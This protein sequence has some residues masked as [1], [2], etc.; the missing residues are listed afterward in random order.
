MLAFTVLPVTWV[1]HVDAALAGP[2]V[3]HHVDAVSV[4]TDGLAG[5]GLCGEPFRAG[6]WYR[7]AD[8]AVRLAVAGSG[9]WELCG[10]CLYRAGW[11]SG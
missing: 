8:G 10:A 11:P 3:L 7:L 5:A 1:G 9:V 2:S 6:S 4:A